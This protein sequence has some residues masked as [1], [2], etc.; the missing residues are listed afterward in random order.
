MPRRRKNDNYQPIGIG[1][2]AKQMKRKKPIGSEMLVD[3]EP[4]T[5]SQKAFFRSYQTGQNL[6]AYG[7]AGT[8]KTFIALYN[9]LADVL[10][11]ITP[12]EKNLCGKITCGN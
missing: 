9:A 2:T 1:M 7:C 10:N 3:I 5:D 11:E 12:Y 6:V 8:G 4:L